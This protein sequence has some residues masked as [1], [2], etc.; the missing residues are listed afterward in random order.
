MLET[1]YLRILIDRPVDEVY[2]FVCNPANL[3]LWASG[4]SGSIRQEGED[5]ISESPMG[6]ARVR[7]A[8]RNPFGVVDHD[9]IIE[10]GESFHNPMRVLK[11]PHGCEVVFTLFHQQGVA[12]EQFEKDAECVH[13]D[14][15]KLKECLESHGRD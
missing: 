4:L 15:E 6:L 1:R 2:E 14:L 11:S 13:R 12:P 10:S 3:P 5:W 9:V 8:D 7:F